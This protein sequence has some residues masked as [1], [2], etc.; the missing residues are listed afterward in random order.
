MLT[1]S[2]GPVSPCF[3]TFIIA[4]AQPLACRWCGLIESTQ[5]FMFK[6]PFIG[7]LSKLCAF[8]LWTIVW[9]YLFWNP[10]FRISFNSETILA[11]LAWLVGIFRTKYI[12]EK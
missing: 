12:F 9:S 4:S 3:T 7:K 8:T 10:V 2:A 6:H 5:C 1:T 11:E